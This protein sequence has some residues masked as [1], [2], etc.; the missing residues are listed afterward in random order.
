M[1]LIE[2]LPKYS[3]FWAV[4]VDDDELAEQRRKLKTPRADRPSIHDWGAVDEL[5]TVIRD[6]LALTRA[7]LIG[8]HSR[9]GKC[10]KVKP[11][12]QP[13]TADDRAERRAELAVHHSIVSKVLPGR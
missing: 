7:V 9:N 2:H 12:P 6:E 1:R 8:V 10:P 5:R 13:I 3:R 4:R 11:Q